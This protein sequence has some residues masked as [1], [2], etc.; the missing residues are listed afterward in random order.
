MSCRPVGGLAF[1][2]Y[3]VRYKIWT[4]LTIVE[5]ADNESIHENYGVEIAGRK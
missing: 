1:R 4:I 2:I 5:N 3:Y